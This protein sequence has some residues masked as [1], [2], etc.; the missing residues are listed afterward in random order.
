MAAI[1]TLTMTLTLM[2][3]PERE[4]QRPCNPYTDAR[5]I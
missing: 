3:M 1:L 5:N 2:S 4:Y